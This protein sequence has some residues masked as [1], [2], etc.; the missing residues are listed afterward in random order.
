VAALDHRQQPK[1]DMPPWQQRMG[2]H[3]KRPSGPRI[4]PGEARKG[5]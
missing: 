4:A 5:E 3:G 1:P 2:D